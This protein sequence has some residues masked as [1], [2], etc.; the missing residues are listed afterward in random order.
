M[1]FLKWPQELHARLEARSEQQGKEVA[2][3]ILRSTS[4]GRGL[5]I[6]IQL[7]GA[8]VAA[9]FAPAII[10]AALHV[11]IPD[12]LYFFLA[13]AAG[14]AWW[15]WPFAKEH[16]VISTFVLLPVGIPLL[17]EVAGKL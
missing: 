7:P 15:K 4:Q 11:K 6:F 5:W 9:A 12:L 16:P 2:D 17:L 14:V 1:G 8:M 3:A 10:A 13:I